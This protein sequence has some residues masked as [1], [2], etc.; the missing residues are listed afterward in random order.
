MKQI[1]L[2]NTLFSDSYSSIISRASPSLVLTVTVCKNGK[3]M[4]GTLC[5]MNAIN[6]DRKGK[7]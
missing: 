4:P 1:G 3:G 2:I 5:H 7:L 6:V